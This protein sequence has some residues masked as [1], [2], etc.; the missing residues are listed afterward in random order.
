MVVFDPDILQLLQMKYKVEDVTFYIEC[1]KENVKQMYDLVKV[2][3]NCGVKSVPGCKL[4]WIC[5]KKICRSCLLL[6][7]RCKFCEVHGKRVLICVCKQQIGA[8]PRS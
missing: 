5:V 3:G 7:C 2:Q 8:W 6:C 4:H 1:T